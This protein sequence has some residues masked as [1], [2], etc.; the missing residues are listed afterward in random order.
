MKN[1]YTQK[2]KSAA[3]V[4]SAAAVIMS[5]APLAAFNAAAASVLVDED[6]SD[7]VTGWSTYVDESASAS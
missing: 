4:F 1:K 3:A 2:L 7:G 6:F 5:C